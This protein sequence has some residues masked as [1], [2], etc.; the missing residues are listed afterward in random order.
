M[1]LFSVADAIGTFAFA[2]SGFLVGARK[3]L[4]WLGITIASVLTALGGG[5]IR[6]VIVGDLPQAFSKQLV[7][8]IIA[9]G[10]ACAWLFRRHNER[11][12]KNIF[13]IV[14]DS[15]GLV[16]FAAS[17]ALIGITHHLNL[18]G[19]LLLAFLTAVGGGIIR[20]V[21]VNEV[22]FVLTSQFYASVALLLAFALYCLNA[23]NLLD[24]VSLMAAASGALALRLA[25][26]FG[27]WNLPTLSTPPK[28]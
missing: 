22:P 26:H 21:L 19:V 18:F 28:E 7:F 2:I 25:A 4:D 15:I 9:A 3:K 14:M 1:T 17:G 23:F 16:A 12:E 27:N 6:D 8:A 20:D 13:F 5:I 11:L 24:S 10:M